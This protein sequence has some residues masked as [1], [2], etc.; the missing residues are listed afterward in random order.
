MLSYHVLSPNAN[1][2]YLFDENGVVVADK[3]ASEVVAPQKAGFSYDENGVVIGDKKET[4]PSSNYQFDENGVVIGD[5]KEA[6]Y[7]QMR[8]LDIYL[9]KMVWL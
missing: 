1:A 6:S 4:L 9:M 2:G 8:M 3:L 5:K 7:H